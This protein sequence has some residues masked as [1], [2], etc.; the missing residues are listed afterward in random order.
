M[1]AGEVSSLSTCSEIE[2]EEQRRQ[3][4]ERQ[5]RRR[6]VLDGRVL[7]AMERVPRHR[8]VDPAYAAQ[9]YDDHPLPIGCGQTISQPYMVARMTELC[10]LRPTDKVLEVGAGCGYQTAVLASLCAQVYAIE[11]LE[12]LARRAKQTLDELGYDITLAVRDGSVGWPEQ[13]PYD[14]ILVAAG[15]PAIPEPLKEQLAEG[16]R[17]VIPVGGRDLQTLRCLTRR[18]AE[19]VVQDDTPCRFVDL[20]GVQGWDGFSQLR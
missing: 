3:M 18:G 12:E 1:A 6:G 17:L 7:Q 9:A 15:A 14:A 8:F 13:A 19:L 20:R 10:A 4:V 2:L 5:I 11:I 16:G